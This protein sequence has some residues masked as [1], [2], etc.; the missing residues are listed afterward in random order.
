MI[1][2]SGSFQPDGSIRG[3]D[4]D[5][6][7]SRY[8][9]HYEESDDPEKVQIYEAI[10]ADAGGSVTTGLLKGLR[11]L[12]D[13]RLLPMGFDKHEAPVD[14]VTQGNARDDD[15][16]VAGGDRL[17]YSVKL[18]QDAGPYNV[19]AELWYQPIGYRRAQNLRNRKAIET[20]Q[21]VSACESMAGVSAAMLAQASVSAP[22]TR[23]GAGA[24]VQSRSKEMA[25]TA[26]PQISP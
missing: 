20:D 15:D 23:P 1:F 17:R 6:D 19:R 14:I 12:K 26:M 13:N 18:R 5:L 3:N 25:M 11:Y 16:F 4:N 22:W 10:M 24:R 2:E 9:P 8:E 7:A 21:F